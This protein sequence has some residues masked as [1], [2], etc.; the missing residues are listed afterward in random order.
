[1]AYLA[2]GVAGYLWWQWREYEN[3]K[4]EIKKL[5]E[6]RKKAHELAKQKEEE[7]MKKLNKDVQNLNNDDIRSL[8]ENF[9][10]L[11]I[12]QKEEEE[13]QY[14]ISNT[15]NNFNRWLNNQV[16]TISINMIILRFNGTVNLARRALTMLSNQ[17]AFRAIRQGITYLGMTPP[18]QRRLINN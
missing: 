15:E 16:I 5:K 4:I 6:Q 8:R 10:E 11:L 2:F 1:M 17:C 13:I 3:E 12:S 14:E 18:S 9:K 7:L